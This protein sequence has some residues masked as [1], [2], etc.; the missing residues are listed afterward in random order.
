MPMNGLVQNNPANDPDSKPIKS[1]SKF[2]PNYSLYQTMLFGRNTPHFAMEVVADD[3]INLRVNT[4]ID[5][6]N[7]KAPLMFPVK[8]YKDYFFVPLRAILPQNADL[9]VTNPRTGMDVVAGNVNCTPKVYSIQSYLTSAAYYINLLFEKN[10]TYSSRYNWCRALLAIFSSKQ[11]FDPFASQGALLNYLGHATNDWLVG[12]YTD[13]ATGR[14]VSYDMLIERLISYAKAHISKFYVQWTYPA[15][16][17]PNASYSN[18]VDQSHYSWVRLDRDIV[19]DGRTGSNREIGLKT[20]LR[21]LDEGYT[22]FRV[23]SPIMIDPTETFTGIQMDDIIPAWSTGYDFHWN[24]HNLPTSTDDPDIQDYLNLSRLVA[25]QLAC[26]QF[27]TS[28]AVDY[29]YTAELYHQNQYSLMDVAWTSFRN[30]RFYTLNGVQ[31]LYDSCSGF[32]IDQALTTVT[33]FDNR[34]NAATGGVDGGPTCTLWAAAARSAINMYLTNIFG[35]QRSLRYR[36]YF[37]G[38]KTRPLAVGDVDVAVDSSTNTVNVVDITK[39]IMRQR[40]LNQVNRIGRTL[41][42]YTRGI[43]GV[44]PMPDP[45]EAVL[46]AST[47]DVIGASETDTNTVDNLTEAQTTSSKLRNSS[48]KYCFEISPTEAGIL[49]GITHFDCVRPYDSVTDRQFFHVDRFDMFNPYLQHIGDQAVYSQEIMPRAA[50]TSP[51]FGYQLRYAE[52]KQRVDRAVG[53]FSDFLPGYAFVTNLLSLQDTLGGVVKISP[54]FIR[55][56]SEEFDRFY[57]SMTNYSL[58]GYFHFICRQDLDVNAVRPMEAAP[59]IL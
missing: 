29:V 56:R 53:G 46:L 54:D 12:T 49:V 1:H 31:Q 33:W 48:S 3:K 36:D 14:E 6:F 8:M 22:L 23:Q 41:K 57:S 30:S 44:T 47:C 4:D 17:N 2:L 18:S 32:L 35:Y 37:V 42:E 24:I 28:D 59:T 11:I 52:Y 26:T 51:I 55:H 13:P 50:A 40:F 45:H 10:T 43:F 34:Y 27:Y 39:N 19:D 21:M 16:Y 58:A 25:Y 7:L 20:F 9:L 15:S 38:S 5:T